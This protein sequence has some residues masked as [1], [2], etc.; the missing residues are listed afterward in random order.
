MVCLVE[1][2]LH[3]LAVLVEG[4]V[5]VLWDDLLDVDGP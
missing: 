3:L 2:V 1:E 5:H 4:L